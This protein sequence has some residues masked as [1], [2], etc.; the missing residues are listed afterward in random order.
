[1]TKKKPI[2]KDRVLIAFLVLLV[3]ILLPILIRSGGGSNDETTQDTQAS[4]QG[5][6][7]TSTDLPLVSIA[8]PSASDD[9]SSSQEEPSMETTAP[10]D[11]DVLSGN[12][13]ILTHVVEA[14]ETAAGIASQM[15]MT[16]EQLL[17][18]NQL[19]STS[20]ITSGRTLYA[21]NLSLIHI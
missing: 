16:V 11:E 21:Y 5:S 3:V 14:G 9:A 13:S 12:S 6:D 20:Q 17:A 10:A 1:M 7:G 19:V 4:A 18:D 15:G 2:R 8:G